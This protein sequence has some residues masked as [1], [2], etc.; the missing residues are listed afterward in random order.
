VGAPLDPA[1]GDRPDRP[2]ALQRLDLG[3]L[4]HTQHD[5]VGGRLQ[6]EPDHVADLG[7][8]L[9]V[10]GELERLG[11]PRLEVVLGP[12]PRDRAVANAQLAGEQ[13][14][15]PVGDAKRLGRWSEGGGQDL[16]TPVAPYRVGGRGGAGQPA[17]RSAPHAHTGGARRSPSGGR[18]QG[19]QRSRCSRRL[20]RPATAAWPAGPARPGPERRSPSAAR[21]QA[22]REEREGR[23]EK[24]AYVNAPPTDP[25]VKSPQRQPTSSQ[26]YGAHFAAGW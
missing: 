4:V 21:P 7:L 9:R 25:T 15:R 6:V 10:G 19:A 13:P 14:A 2:G 24:T 1:R 3:L 11:L 5:R 8:Q 26:K 23:R 12:Y 20:Q 18:C 22:R 16:G 17:G